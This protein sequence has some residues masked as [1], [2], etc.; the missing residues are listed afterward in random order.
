MIDV[1]NLHKTYPGGV[2]AVRDISFSVR[3]GEV[4][5]LLGPNGAGK[6][7]TIGMLTT[8]RPAD[9]GNGQPRR[10]RRGRRSA[11]GAGRERGRVPGRGGRR[12]AD[13]AQEPR[14]PRRAS[15]GSTHRP[16]SCGSTTSS[17]RSISE[18]WSTGRCDLQRRRAA[19]ARDRA[20]AGVATAACCSS[21]NRRSGSTR[22]SG[23]ELLDVIG[24]LRDSTR[25]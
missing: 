10:I 3:A 8:T 22:G 20:I 15:G 1:R 18:R 6:S 21:T 16:A 13:R 17:T 4:F 7:T 9:V 2:E 14:D 5:G 12:L 23:Y 19:P 25:R 11:R 24:G